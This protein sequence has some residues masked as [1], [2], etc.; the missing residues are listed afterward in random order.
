M[1]KEFRKPSLLEQFGLKPDPNKLEHFET[2]SG[3]RLTRVYTQGGHA[4]ETQ[5][6]SLP[7]YHRR[8]GK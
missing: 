5:Q 6:K 8:I 2:P 7:I 4:I 1:S 3:N